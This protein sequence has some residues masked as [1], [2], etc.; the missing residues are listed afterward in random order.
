LPDT[1]EGVKQITLVQRLV[2]LLMG[3]A[4]GTLSVKSARESVSK[5]LAAEVKL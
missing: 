2:K 1:A 5:V 4:L 3:P